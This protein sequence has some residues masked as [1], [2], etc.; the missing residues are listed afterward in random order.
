[1]KLNEGHSSHRAQVQPPR[2]HP[3]IR[4]H[5]ACGGRDQPRVRKFESCLFAST[6]ER[7]AEAAGRANEWN[8]FSARAHR[9]VWLES[10]LLLPR[11]QS[12][13]HAA[14]EA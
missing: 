9:L 2:K 3:H 8:W 5:D 4:R 13:I 10:R 7:H 11:A 12:Y 6:R 1:M 14:V